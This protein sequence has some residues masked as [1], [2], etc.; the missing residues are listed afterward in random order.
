MEDNK[1]EIKEKISNEIV[2]DTEIFSFGY[3]I[4]IILDYYCETSNTTDPADLWKKGTEH[5]EKNA[6]EIP[7]DIDELVKKA[8]KSQ[9]KKFS[10]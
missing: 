2:K 9:L 3:L 4:N 5:E 8:F 10:K 1:E 7:D 6:P